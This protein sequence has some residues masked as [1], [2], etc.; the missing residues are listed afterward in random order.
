M[1]ELCINADS[2]EKRTFSFCYILLS[3]NCI[4]TRLK[5]FLEIFADIFV[6]IS[7]MS[8]FYDAVWLHY[9]MQAQ[10]K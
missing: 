7:E 10:L 9:P 6:F 2:V 5:L 1:I 3:R 8:K 4:T